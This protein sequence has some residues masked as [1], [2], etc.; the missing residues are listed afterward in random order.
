L[1]RYIQLRAERFTRAGF[2]GT[3]GSG[4]GAVVMGIEDEYGVV[5]V[6]GVLRAVAVM[7]VPID[8]QHSFHTI[9]FLNVSGSDRDVVVNAETHST[10][11]RGVMARRAHRAES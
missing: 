2:C 10:R 8:D 4:I 11:W 7:V 6:K 9:G 3:A 5:F 1:H